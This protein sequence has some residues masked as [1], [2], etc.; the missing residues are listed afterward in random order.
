MINPD[1]SDRITINGELLGTSAQTYKVEY[2][3]IDEYDPGMVYTGSE[4]AFEEDYVSGDPGGQGN[5]AENYL[6]SFLG[7]S[8]TSVFAAAARYSE[9]MIYDYVEQEVRDYLQQS[10]QKPYGGMEFLTLCRQ[11]LQVK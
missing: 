10:G 8:V 3:V 5:I 4:T 7:G 9:V 2:G 11:N 6:I 1:S